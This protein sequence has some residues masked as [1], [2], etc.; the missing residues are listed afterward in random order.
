MTLSVTD[1]SR[2]SGCAASAAHRT[3]LQLAYYYL[4][5]SSSGVQRAVRM[6]KYLPVFGYDLKLK[7]QIWKLGVRQNRLAQMIEFTKRC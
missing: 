7:L 2:Q 6:V 1:P 3:L 5:D 4:P